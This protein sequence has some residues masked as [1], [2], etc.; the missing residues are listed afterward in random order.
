VRC[1]GRT[2]C[3][4]RRSARD[5]RAWVAYGNLQPL[6]LPDTLDPLAVDCPARL[7]QQRGDL[8]IAISAVL[9]AKL[10]SLISAVRHRSSSRPCGTLRCVEAPSA[11][12]ARRSETCSCARTCSM[13]SAQCRHGDARGLEVSPGGLPQ[14]ELVQRQTALRS[15]LFSSSRSFRRFTCSVFSPPNSWRHQMGADHL[16]SHTRP[17]AL[18]S[19]RV[20]RVTLLYVHHSVAP[21]HSPVRRFGQHTATYPCVWALQC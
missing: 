14:N 2:R 10:A 21:P 1:C 3:K 7:A 8:A 17:G 19:R 4:I 18:P 5:C 9:A 13:L 6:T 12:Q 15:R 20:A 11:V 16:H